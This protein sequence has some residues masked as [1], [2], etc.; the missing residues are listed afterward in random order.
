MLR[1]TH[2]ACHVTI[3]LLPNRD[4]Y[5]VPLYCGPDTSLILIYLRVRRN[6]IYVAQYYRTRKLLMSCSSHTWVCDYQMYYTSLTAQHLLLCM[7][8]MI[9]LVCYSRDIMLYKSGHSIMRRTSI[10]FLCLELA[11][12]LIA[13][14]MDAFI[15]LNMKIKILQVHTVDLYVFGVC[16]CIYASVRDTWIIYNI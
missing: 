10:V 8:H 12:T 15:L 6:N 3:I 13:K 7:L 11:E 5:Q 14:L 2:I 1:Y 4:C 9:A 16:V